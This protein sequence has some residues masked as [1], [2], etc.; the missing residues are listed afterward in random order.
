MINTRF[1]AMLIMS[2]GETQRS[3]EAFSNI[4]ILVLN[5]EFKGTASAYYY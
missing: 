4:L 1:R 2:R 3:I 5:G